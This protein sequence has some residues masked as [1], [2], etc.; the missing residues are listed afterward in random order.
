MVGGESRRNQDAEG[1]EGT[2]WG[3]CPHPHILGVSIK[4]MYPSDRYN[5]CWGI[6]T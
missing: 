2:E 4:Q 1:V 5:S 3:G 6:V